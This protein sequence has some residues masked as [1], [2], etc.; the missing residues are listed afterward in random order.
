MVSAS[1][2]LSSSPWFSGTAAAPSLEIAWRLTTSQSARLTSSVQIGFITG[3]LIY[4]LLNLADVFNACRVFFVSAILGGFFNVAFAWLSG[5]LT[6]ALILRF[7]LGVTLPG[8]YPVG[9]KIVATWFRSGLGFGLGVMVGA[10][11]LE[12]AS[13]FWVV[14]QICRRGESSNEI[15]RCGLCALLHWHADFSTIQA[16]EPK[17]KDL[18]TFRSSQTTWSGLCR[19]LCHQ[20]RRSQTNWPWMFLQLKGMDGRF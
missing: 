5:G 10:L 13:P 9:M 18:S 2:L 12:T 4:A 15:S 3:K 1:V 19:P 6:S 7:L 8:M 16:A 20:P 17:L 11:T 14:L